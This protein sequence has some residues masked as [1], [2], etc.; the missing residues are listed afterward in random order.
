MKYAFL[1]LLLISSEVYS[2]T[3]S[4][5]SFGEE[6]YWQNTSQNVYLNTANS[7]AVTNTSLVNVLS[8]SKTEFSNLGFNLNVIETTGSAVNGRNDIYFTNSTSTFGGS[9]VLALT[10][11]SFEEST[12]AI[13]EADILINDAVFF[14]STKGVGN[15][16]GDLLS[17][18]LG[19]FVGLGHSEVHGSSMF[20]SIFNGQDTLHSDDQAA[21][22]HIYSNTTELTGRVAGGSNVGIFGAHVQ[23]ISS[24]DG[25]VKASTVSE[26]DGSFTISGL[27]SSDTY[28]IYVEPLKSIDNLTSFYSTVRDNFCTSQT[29]YRGTFLESC[30]NSEKGKPQGVV[31]GGSS[32]NV[33][34]ISIGCDLSVPVNY[35]QNKP[36]NLNQL[37]IVDVFGNAGEVVTGYFS[38][39]EA[40]NNDYDEYEIDLTNYNVPAGDIYLDIKMVSQKLFSPTRLSLSSV[41]DTIVYETGADGDGLRFDTDGNVDLDAI[42]RIKLSAVA[43]SNTFRFKVTPETLEDFIVGK[44]YSV[45]SFLPSSSIYKD[46]LNFYMMILTI[47][48]KEFGVFTKISE[49]VYNYQ[50]NLSCLDGPSSYSVSQGTQSKSTALQ[51]LEKRKNKDDS[52][53][54]SCATVEFPKGPGSGGMSFILA[55]MLGLLST[56]LLRGFKSEEI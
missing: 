11:V 14:S 55:F 33:G 40:T 16:L 56:S 51:E 39:S 22:S 21:V 24:S 7:S 27:S 5:G 36:S 54:L 53:A 13:Q 15:Y 49:K 37:N 46:D 28:Y 42:G 6:I 1:I 26:S 38:P 4:R 34:T 47:S 18:E 9:S 31:M 45:D 52:T 17:H 48:K 3:I 12:G 10:K 20:F 8:T 30:R 23:A 32:R 44:A 41:T 19:H 25:K 29:S 35:M 43:A 2:Y 50:E